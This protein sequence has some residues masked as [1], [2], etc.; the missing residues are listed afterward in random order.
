MIAEVFA[1]RSW[2]YHAANGGLAAAVS[3]VSIGGFDKTYDLSDE[4]LI[5][6]GAGIVAGFAYWL[7]RRLERGILGSRCSRRPGPPSRR[8]SRRSSLPHSSRTLLPRPR[9]SLKKKSPGRTRRYATA[10]IRTDK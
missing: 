4:P 9:T 7:D 1:I 5:A 10:P 2:M 8:P 6:V 3:L